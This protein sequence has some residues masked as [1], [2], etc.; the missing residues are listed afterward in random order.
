MGMIDP[1]PLRL[2]DVNMLRV[3][4]GM[5]EKTEK[6]FITRHAKARMR[7][8]R[9]TSAQ[10]YACLRHGNIS[11]SAHVDISGDWKGTLMHRHA[12]DEGHVAAALRRNE[13]GDWIAVVT[14]F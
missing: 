2:N 4:R 11:E 13:N 12:G 1:T 10:V 5:A 6:V 14:V 7:E 8:R 9:I 3:I